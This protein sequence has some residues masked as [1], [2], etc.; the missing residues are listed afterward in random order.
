MAAVFNARLD[1][2]LPGLRL[3]TDLLDVVNSQRSRWADVELPPSVG[4]EVA[5]ALRREIGTAFVGGF[6]VLMVI[7]AA[8][9]F[10]SSMTAWLTIDRASAGRKSLPRG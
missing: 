2:A 4:G 8:L 6:R 5:E 1:D 9:C 7:A 3:S 10:L